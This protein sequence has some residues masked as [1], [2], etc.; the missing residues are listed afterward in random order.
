MNIFA[1]IKQTVSAD[2]HEFLD[3]KEQKNPISLLNE[4]LRQCEAETEK[5][6]QL[7]QRQYILKDE[8]AREY[9]EALDLANK[10]KQQAEIAERAR[11]LELHS[12]ASK[13]S[14]Q[15]EERSNHL[16]QALNQAE[17]QLNEL[18]R[19][20]QDMK[21]K[22]KDMKIRRLELMGRENVA[23]ANQRINQV[24][25]A[26]HS[27]SKSVAKFEEIEQ[28]IDRL[29]YDITSSYHRNTIDARIVQ[30]EK[31]LKNKET[32]SIS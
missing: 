1:R 3:K 15:Y 19:K 10:R 12:F 5:V 9:G 21:H 16:N 17:K 14:L 26:T 4:Y 2:F 27:S 20:Y 22:V 8:F 25:D 30:L 31:E 7:L 6:R 23:R 32:H 11:E 13:E 24:V 18:E 28:Y 29:E